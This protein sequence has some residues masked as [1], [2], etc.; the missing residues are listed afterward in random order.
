MCG[1][2]GRLY[3]HL[4]LTFGLLVLNEYSEI[5]I[6]VVAF[7]SKISSE[8]YVG[9]GGVCVGGRGGCILSSH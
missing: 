3:S 4:P 6:Q 2:Q 9:W 7:Y 1:E 8:F 5:Y